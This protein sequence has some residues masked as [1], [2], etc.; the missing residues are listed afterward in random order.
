MCIALS[1]TS[2]SPLLGP[3]DVK[4]LATRRAAKRAART[5]AELMQDRNMQVVEVK[6]AIEP[7]ASA[8]ACRIEA[9]SS[10]DPSPAV[11]FAQ[12]NELASRLS[13]QPQSQ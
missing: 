3:L 10:L 2:D 11:Q 7:A 13:W 6:V 1:A 9:S 8:F 12:A 4:R 5:K